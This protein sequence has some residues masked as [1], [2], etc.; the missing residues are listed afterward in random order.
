[1]QELKD[2]L[3][4]NTEEETGV[5]HALPP[6]NDP[7]ADAFFRLAPSF[8][9]VP[10][11]EWNRYQY[12]IPAPPTVNPLDWWR[13]RAITYPVLSAIA[14]RCLCIPASSA[15]A[16]RNFSTAGLTLDKKRSRLDPSL[17]DKL[18]F[19]NKS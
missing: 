8:D 18:V 16:E 19:L 2:E 7:I 1:M 3:A 4:E 17:V 13:E 15:T 11:D 10:N 9:T 12:E 14:K 5:G 6:S